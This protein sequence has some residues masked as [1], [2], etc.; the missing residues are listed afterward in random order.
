M[1]PAAPGLEY[2]FTIRAEIGRT[3]TAGPSRNGERLHIEIAG[4]RVEGPRLG[5]TIAPGGSDWPLLRP[6]GA[7]RISACYTIVAFDG[8]PILVRNEGLRV[9]SAN[10]LARLRAGEAVDPSEFYFR[11]TPV[12][13]APDGPHAWLNDA[14]FVASL[15][16]SGGEVVVDVY[17]VT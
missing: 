6:D 1:R 16:R 15:C 4:G 3:L 12:F 14:V 17:R 5:G 8:T 9:S 2:A 10:V 7:S 13:E 11:T